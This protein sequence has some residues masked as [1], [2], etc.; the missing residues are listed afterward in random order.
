MFQC[1]LTYIYLR[2]YEWANFTV[3]LTISYLETPLR[4]VHILLLASAY[5]AWTDQ[6]DVIKLYGYK[7]RGGRSI[8]S[9]FSYTE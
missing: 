7:G 4:R 9:A 5:W 2:C 8:C 3:S 6:M 1:V